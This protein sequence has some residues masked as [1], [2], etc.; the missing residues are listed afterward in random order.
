M[1]AMIQPA[2]RVRPHRLPRCRFSFRP[3]VE[4]LEERC[5]LSGGSFLFEPVIPTIDAGMKANLQAILA[6]GLQLGNRPDV[7]AKIGDSITA[8]PN[9][10]FALGNPAY[11]PANPFF[12]GAFTNIASTVNYFRAQ[13]VD[14][15]GANSFNR[16]SLAGVNGWS[17]FQELD[18]A[19]DLDAVRAPFALPGETP[20]ATEVRITKPGIALIMLGTNDLG[21]GENLALFQAELTAV[22]QT[23][24]A[25]GVIPVLSTIP[26]NLLFG[27]SAEQHVFL[28][29]QIISDVAASLNVPLW[30]YWLALQPLPQKGLGPDGGHPSAYPFGTEF[31]TAN[32][33]QFGYNVRNLT[34]VGVLMKITQVVYDDGPADVLA[35]AAVPVVPAKA[36]QP[37]GKGATPAALSDSAVALAIG[38]IAAEP[39]NGSAPIIAAAS[40]PPSP[41]GQI[42]PSG[43]PI[44]LASSAGQASPF[45]AHVG[46]PAIEMSL[47]GG[48]DRVSPDIWTSETEGKATD[49][50]ATPAADEDV[51]GSPGSSTILWIESGDW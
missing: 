34:A 10:L 47:P 42:S 17:P 49:A 32:G 25:D 29:N 4:L 45:P 14:A 41:A 26:D 11:D 19:R 40:L 43:V 51:S 9:F 27:P 31:F 15:S 3:Q 21:A 24:I 35:P 6:H 36:A 30:N 39:A 46:E 18:P 2:S 50:T 5:V 8:S 33:L 12:S 28:N 20:L 1:T 23:V 16:V 7:F 13:T 48:S 44:N 37:A 22:V 38:G